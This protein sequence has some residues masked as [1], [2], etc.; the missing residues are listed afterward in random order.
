MHEPQ[1]NTPEEHSGGRKPASV[2]FTQPEPQSGFKADPNFP[3]VKHVR[4]ANL[5]V[6]AHSF[7]FLYKLH[8]KIK[9]PSKQ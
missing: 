1:R 6:Y 4:F 3:A 9:T 2:L 7:T 5:P 8:N